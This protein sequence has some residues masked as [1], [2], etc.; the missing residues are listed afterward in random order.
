VHQLAEEEMIQV[1]A[2]KT[3]GI[4]L[5]DRGEELSEADVL[6]AWWR[7]AGP[8]ALAG[9]CWSRRPGGIVSPNVTH[10]MLQALTTKGL[11]E[12]LDLDFDP[13]EDGEGEG[14]GGHQAEAQELAQRQAHGARSQRHG[15]KGR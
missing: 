8:S 12:P 3:R 11:P 4:R 9:T 1:T 5:V 10:L 13:G 15:R 2:G 14:T 7:W 6:C